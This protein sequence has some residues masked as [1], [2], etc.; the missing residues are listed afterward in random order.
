[1]DREYLKKLAHQ[2]MFELSEEEIEELLQSFP[3]WEEQF[4]LLN[5]LD[6]DDAEAM[7]F[8][9][10]AVSYWLREDVAQEPL[11][12]KQVF[13]NAAVVKDGMIVVAKAADR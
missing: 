7:F 5:Q 4:S 9:S 3:L 13:E 2:L 6:T 10:D 11:S 1:M 12:H 8:P